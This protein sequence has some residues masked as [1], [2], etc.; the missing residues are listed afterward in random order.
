M[1]DLA[2]ELAEQLEMHLKQCDACQ[3]RYE[4]QKWLMTL[5]QRFFATKRRLA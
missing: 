4:E 5:L 2:R 1:G 3:H